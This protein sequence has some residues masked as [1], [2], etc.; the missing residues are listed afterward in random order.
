MEMTSARVVNI[1]GAHHALASRPPAGPAFDAAGV[2]IDGWLVQPALNRLTRDEVSVRLR[3]QLMDVIVCLASQP[4]RVF[5][6][7]ELVARVW[8]GRLVA[9]SAVSR[10]IAELRTVFA[11]DAQRPHVIETIPKRGYRLIAPVER[12]RV[13]ASLVLS[14]VGR[15]TWKSAPFITGS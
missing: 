13:S 15:S 12:V 14:K 7:D 3:P 5:G 1:T 2:R 10:C 11:D 8:D 6:K 4:G 9:G